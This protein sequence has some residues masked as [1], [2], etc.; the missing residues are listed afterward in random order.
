[1]EHYRTLAVYAQKMKFSFKY[2]SS[3][4]D[5]IRRKRRIQSHLLKKS[6]M[7]NVIFCTLL[8]KFFFFF[9]L[10]F[11][12][13]TFANHSTAGEGGGHFFFSSLPLP[14]ASQT[15]RHQLGD[16]CRQ[17]TSAHSQ[18]PDSNREPLFSERKSL[19]TKLRALI[20]VALLAS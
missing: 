13:R 5:Q 7:E 11:L 4:C 20:Y 19:A 18:Q 15:L 10:G 8:P 6:L 1:M 14:P 2:F 3:K 9:Y 12:S 16:Y 17:L